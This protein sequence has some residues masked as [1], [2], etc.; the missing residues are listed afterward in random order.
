[1]AHGDANRD[2]RNL[3]IEVVCHVDEAVQSAG[4]RHKHGEVKG[5]SMAVAE[6]CPGSRT[7]LHVRGMRNFAATYMRALRRRSLFC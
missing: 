2:I 7:T 3:P 5:T 1:M 6:R 4:A